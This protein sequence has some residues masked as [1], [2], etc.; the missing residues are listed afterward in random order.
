MGALKVG[1]GLSLEE[2]SA[3]AAR[4]A[5]LLALDQAGLKAASWALCF[6]SGHHMSGAEAMRGAI[7]E[8]TGC[9]S[10][11]GCSS[12]GVIVQGEEVESGPALA[13]MV[14][15]GGDVETRSA[16]LPGDGQG[17][18]EFQ[19]AEGGASGASLLIAL[20]DAF[21]VDINLVRNRML[22]ETPHLPIYGAGATDD[23]RVGISLQLG[24]EGVRNRSISL[25]GLSGAFEVA[26]GITQSCTLLGEPHF[27]TAS[28]ENVLIELDGRSALESLIEQGQA[29][30]LDDFQ[31]LA[32][33]VMFGFPLDPENPQFTGETCLVRALGGLDQDS[34]GLVI[35]Y[36]LMNQTSVAF[37]HRNP[38]AA[39]QDMQRMVADVQGRLSGPPELGIYFDCAA[40]GQSFY[41]RPGVDVEKIGGQLGNF[42]IIGMYGGFELATALGLPHIYTY[43]G[44]LVLLRGLN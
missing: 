42:P 9:S 8:A 28:R 34:H 4:E 16:L 33:Q 2:D 32:M 30:G 7:L 17:L 27:I 5:A 43:T 14:G 13:L 10:L 19:A 15:H 37:M 18:A 20:P 39:E 26:V 41:G 38:A 3:G 23:G 25:L 24:M 31:Q 1:V 35:P 40:R 44:V 11:G 36:S 6:F 21:Q 12:M 22:A 29:L